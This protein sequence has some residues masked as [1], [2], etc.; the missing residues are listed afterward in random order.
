MITNDS[1]CSS[2][3][4][5]PNLDLR[6]SPYKPNLP[7]THLSNTPLEFGHALKYFLV[8]SNLYKH[9]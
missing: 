5:S 8:V 9:F 3:T 4:L 1:T 2:T 7:I 6:F